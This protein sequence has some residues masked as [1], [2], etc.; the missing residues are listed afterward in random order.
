MAV[1]DAAAVVDLLLRNDL[2]Q[3]VQE[4]IEGRVLW[5]VAHVDAE[6]FSALTSAPRRRTLP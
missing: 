4:R 2:G 5:S 3:A 6:A 1:P